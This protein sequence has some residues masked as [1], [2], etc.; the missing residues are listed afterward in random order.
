MANPSRFEVGHLVP[1]TILGTSKGHTQVYNYHCRI[2]HCIYTKEPQITDKAAIPNH[3]TFGIKI[4][5]R[6]F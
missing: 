3:L 2:E 4:H 5:I 1:C 6:G